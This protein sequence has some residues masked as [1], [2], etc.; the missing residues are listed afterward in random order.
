MKMRPALGLKGVIVES[1]SL[2][3]LRVL[4]ILSSV[5]QEWI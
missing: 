3:K 5:E 2:H 1:V 4:V